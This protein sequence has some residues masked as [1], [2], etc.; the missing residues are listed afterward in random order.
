[1][2]KKELGARIREARK[3]KKLT[4]ETLAEIA[5]IGVMY[6]GEIE[7]GQKMPSMN[8]F[9]KLINALDVSSDYVLR[10]QVHSGKNYI[11]DEITQ[12]LEPLDPKQRKTVCDLIDAYLKNL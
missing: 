2:E 8:I 1:M 4:Q 9:I 3:A 12:K 10:G 6:L 7:R 11:F 5:G